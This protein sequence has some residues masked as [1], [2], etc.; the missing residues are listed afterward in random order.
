MTVRVVHATVATDPQEPRLDHDDWNADHVVEGVPIFVQDTNPAK[1]YP[2]LWVDISG[3]NISFW[4]E[5]GT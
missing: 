3:G 5:D 1:D 4:V 2:Y